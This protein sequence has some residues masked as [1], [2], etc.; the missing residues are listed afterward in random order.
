MTDIAVRKI[1]DILNRFVT[2]IVED[3]ST[4]VYKIGDN[5]VKVTFD[6]DFELPEQIVV[7]RNGDKYVWVNSSTATEKDEKLSSSWSDD[8]ES[9]NIGDHDSI[10]FKDIC[11]R[12]SIVFTDEDWPTDVVVTIDLED[13]TLKHLEDEM[14]KTGET[15]DQVMNRILTAAI[16]SEKEKVNEL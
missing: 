3:T 14:E 1:N 6:K 9:Y 13:E 4:L 8:Y 2:P 16:E 10:A 15:M 11:Q 12:A 7:S 5:S